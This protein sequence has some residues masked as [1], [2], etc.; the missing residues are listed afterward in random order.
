MKKWYHHPAPK[1]SSLVRKGFGNC[2]GWAKLAASIAFMH[3]KSVEAITLR[4]AEGSAHRVLWV[5]KEWFV[6]NRDVHRAR[7]LG[8]ILRYFETP[9]L[10]EKRWKLTEVMDES[11]D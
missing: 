1:L 10:V 7:T 4:T 5:D 2:V 8:A 6:T 3:G 9:Y 11:L